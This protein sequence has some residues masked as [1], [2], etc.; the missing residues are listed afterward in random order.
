M[1]TQVGLPG[2]VLASMEDTTP[3][4]VARRAQ[5]IRDMAGML[6][7][8]HTGTEWDAEDGE[9]GDVVGEV[10]ARVASLRGELGLSPDDIQAVLEH[11]EQTLAAG[12]GNWPNLLDRR[13][14][15]SQGM[16]G[17]DARLLASRELAYRADERYPT[18]TRR[19]GHVVIR[20]VSSWAERFRLS[21]TRK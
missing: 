18:I 20:T 15:S 12:G 11:H 2:P 4:D 1:A 5:C 21:S 6:V 3:M 7:L 17:P 19:I 14:R 10:G 16:I 13:T 9:H 8:V